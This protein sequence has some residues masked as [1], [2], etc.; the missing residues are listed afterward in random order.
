MKYVTIIALLLIIVAPAHAYIDG[1]T[2]SYVVQMTMAGALA[3]VF[4]VKLAWQR[5]RT[6]IS[7]AFSGSSGVTTPEGK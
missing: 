7:K 3:V 2:G 6:S 5:I 1:G 4:S